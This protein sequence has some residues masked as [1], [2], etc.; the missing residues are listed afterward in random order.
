MLS[1]LDA[2]GLGALAA[3]AIDACQGE[4]HPVDGD[5]G[6]EDRT[7][8]PLTSGYML[9]HREQAVEDGVGGARP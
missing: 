5:E 4:A 7:R 1:D 9:P 3:R 8:W 6:W 2:E